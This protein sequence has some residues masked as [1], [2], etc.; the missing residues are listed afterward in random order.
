MAVRP[1]EVCIE[2]EVAVKVVLLLA[3]D[4]ECILGLNVV[5]LPQPAC[6]VLDDDTF[7]DELKAI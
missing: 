7:D 4:R 1:L 2:R 6:V 3:V 5:D